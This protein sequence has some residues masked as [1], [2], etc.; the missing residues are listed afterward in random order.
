MEY[1][2]AIPLLQEILPLDPNN[3]EILSNLGVAMIMGGSASKGQQY[4]EKAQSLDPN[5]KFDF[6][7]KT[8]DQ[9]DG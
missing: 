6:G 9:Y 4:L 2:G 8:W 5:I 7:I 3:T 1:K